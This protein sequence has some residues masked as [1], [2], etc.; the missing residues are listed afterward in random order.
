MNKNFNEWRARSPISNLPNLLKVILT[1][2][3]CNPLH[4]INLIPYFSCTY[5]STSLPNFTFRAQYSTTSK[6]RPMSLLSQIRKE[7][8]P[9]I[10]MSRV[11]LDWIAQSGLQSNLV[12]WIVIDNPKSKSDFGF[13]LSIH[14]LYFNPN[15][16]AIIFLIKKLK[17]HGQSCSSNTSQAISYHHLSSI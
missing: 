8:K 13:G 7:H 4:K 2:V 15:P 12:D 17:T 11:L 10:P 14:F 16:K 5:L 6:L 1:K 9:Q 3:Y